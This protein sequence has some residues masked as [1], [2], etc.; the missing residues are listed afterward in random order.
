MKKR[1]LISVSDK[2]GV[3]D[4]AKG[5]ESLGFEII[6]TGG[7]LDTLKN[8]GIAAISITDVTGFAECLDGRVKTLHPAVHAGLLALRDNKEHMSHLAKL[9]LGTID[10]V[11]VNLYPFKAT[12]LKDGTTF[13]D[14]VENI[15]IGGPTMLRSAAKNY[16]SVAVVIDPVDYTTVLDK[17]RTGNIDEQYRLNLMYKVFAHT[18]A[19]DSMIAEHLRSQV[20]INL[21]DSLTLTFEKTQD[22]RYGENPQQSA[23][24]YREAIPSA[25]G[26]SSAVQLQGKEL[27]Y[28]NIND[29]NAALALLAEFDTPSIVAVK[30]ANPCGVASG[31]NVFEAYKGAYDCDPI[32]IFGGIVACNREVDEKS[33]AEMAKI[34]LEIVIAPSFSQKALEVF[35][36]K[37]NL[38]VMQLNE[39]SRYLGQVFDT[40]KVAGGLL[41]QSEDIGLFDES[42]VKC[43]TKK[44]PTAAQM[45]ALKFAFAVVKH[46]KSNAIVLSKGTQTIGLGSGQTNRI[47]ATN[48]AI[49]HAGDRTKGAVLASDAFFPFDDCVEAAAKAGVSAIIQPGGSNRD[50]DSIAACDKYGI[51]MIF[52]GNRH[53][54]H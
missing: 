16:K 6:S 28:N 19:Y 43:V 53:F 7:T 31:K 29:A 51:A 44:K 15:D 52:V 34:F 23:A 33:A 27:S 14:A 9:G 38:R 30:H 1:A 3:V 12:I 50:A 46:T 10:V 40:K 32:S 4:F 18:A 48:Q 25:G 41:I 13:E 8:N 35:K 24:F 42:A 47:W 2:S 36:S 5:L 39:A 22:L 37:P 11:A 20:G 45:N 26:I 17:L 21:P 54:K 49:E